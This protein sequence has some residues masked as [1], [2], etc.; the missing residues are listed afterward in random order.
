MMTTTMMMVMD[1][2]ED[3]GVVL[4]RPSRLISKV[5]AYVNMEISCVP[6]REYYMEYY[7]HQLHNE[8]FFQ[9]VL[10]ILVIQH[11]LYKLFVKLICIHTLLLSKLICEEHGYWQVLF[12][13][14]LGSTSLCIKPPLIHNHFIIFDC[15]LA[16]LLPNTK[17]HFT[18]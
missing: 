5:I 7:C 15:Y 3:L 2:F 18:F 8:F 11:F 13:M 16:R 14:G 17:L 6:H 4:C 9:E 10:P 1:R 12:W